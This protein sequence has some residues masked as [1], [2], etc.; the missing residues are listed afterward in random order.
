VD[1]GGGSEGRESDGS[2]AYVLFDGAVAGSEVDGPQRARDARWMA[3]KLLAAD[4][5]A[6]LTSYGT[7]FVK[8]R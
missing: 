3:K 2:R 5:R 8:L 7:T 6:L 4:S 1:E